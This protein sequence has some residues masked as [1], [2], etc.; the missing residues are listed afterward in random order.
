MLMDLKQHFQYWSTLVETL[1]LGAALAV[2][3]GQ[4][5]TQSTGSHT[6]NLVSGQHATH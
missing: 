3:D 1:T 2:K 6:P 5:E 4:A